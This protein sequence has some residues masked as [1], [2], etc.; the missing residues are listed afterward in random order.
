[1]NGSTSGPLGNPF[2]IRLKG[3]TDPCV[4]AAAMEG[5]GRVWAWTSED[6]HFR[7]TLSHDFWETLLRFPN[8]PEEALILGAAQLTLRGASQIP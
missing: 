3:L 6:Y 5:P 8:Y 2:Q 7:S 1:M 4:K